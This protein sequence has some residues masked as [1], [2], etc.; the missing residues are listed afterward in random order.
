MVKR[1]SLQD[2]LAMPI[3]TGFDTEWE[4]ENWEAVKKLA[5]EY[6]EEAKKTVFG[7]AIKEL[8]KVDGQKEPV[9]RDN[10][11]EYFPQFCQESCRIRA[12]KL[13][14]VFPIL[15]WYI[16]PPHCI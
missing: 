2:F 9:W 10:L 4:T 3:E 1:Y 14:Q 8:E 11:F 16:F 13:R 6:P 12:G 5:M 15:L 7:V